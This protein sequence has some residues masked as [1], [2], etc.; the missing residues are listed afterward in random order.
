MIADQIIV[1]KEKIGGDNIIVEVDEP[2]Y[3]S[4]KFYKGHRVQGT[5]IIGGVE[6]TPQKRFFA[7]EDRTT[8]TIINI[9]HEKI[10]DGSIIYTDYWKSYD[11]AIDQIN[12][13]FFKL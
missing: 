10:E 12:V 13:E 2:K 1:N 6:R 3:G 8:E 9:I 11:S 5:W 4:R 7:V